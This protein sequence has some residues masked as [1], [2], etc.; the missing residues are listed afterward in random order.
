M[1]IFLINI[2]L[3][4]LFPWV[5]HPWKRRAGYG[6]SHPQISVVGSGT[7]PLRMPRADCTHLIK[8]STC[9]ESSITAT[10][11]TALIV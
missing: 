7:S 8:P 1:H 11:T 6:T 9:N 5:L 3:T 4:L 10:T 2:Q